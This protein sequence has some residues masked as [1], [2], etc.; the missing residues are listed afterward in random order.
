LYGIKQRWLLILLAGIVG[1]A[2]S[3]R[4][5]GVA[6]L[7]TLGLAIWRRSPT[8]ISAVA[9]A[10]VLLPVACWGIAAY[11]AYQAAVF[12]DPLA[13]AR[14]Q[15]NWKLRPPTPIFGKVV[16]LATFEPVWSA[17]DPGRPSY[18]VKTGGTSNLLFNLRAA[19]PAYFLGAVILVAVGAARRWLSD[20]EVVTAAGL[21]LIPYATIGYDQYMQSMGRYSS[22][23]F[24]IYLVLGHILGRLPGPAASCLAAI[25]GF[26][27]GIYA[28]MFSSWHVFL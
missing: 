18:W 13:F 5:V 21:L 7:P 27:L 25:C 3:T 8:R 1:L 15:A 6:L 28:A 2:T 14:T 16:D 22:S 4:P 20:Y 9:R 23:V 12:G 26:L 24:P 11:M 19:D 17:Y 10:T